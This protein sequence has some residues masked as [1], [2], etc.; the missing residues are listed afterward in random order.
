MEGGGVGQRHAPAALP[1]RKGPGTHCTGGWE[2]P[3]AGLDWF[4]EKNISC[5]HRVSDPEPSS[6]YLV[7]QIRYPGP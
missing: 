2:G 3:R 7:Y 5:T 1:P 6:Q 4:G